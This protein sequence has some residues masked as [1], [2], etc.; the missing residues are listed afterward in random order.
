MS[1]LGPLPE[2]EASFHVDGNGNWIEG[3]NGTDMFTADQMRSYAQQEV[4][5]ERE[6]WRTAAVYAVHQLEK[7][8]IWGGMGWQYNPLHPLHYRSALE[9]LRDVLEA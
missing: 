7:A 4:E 9:R 5:K 8:R 1:E 2:P 6:R 3:K